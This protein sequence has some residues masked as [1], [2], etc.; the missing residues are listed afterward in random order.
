VYYVVG[1]DLD[2]SVGADGD[3]GSGA[4]PGFSHCRS[5]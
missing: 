1:V 2:R 3:N 5:P 4:A